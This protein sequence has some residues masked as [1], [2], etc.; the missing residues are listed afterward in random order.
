VPPDKHEDFDTTEVLG[1]ATVLQARGMLELR[2][3][4][5]RPLHFD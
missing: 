5:L 2:G 3:D 1:A 4:V